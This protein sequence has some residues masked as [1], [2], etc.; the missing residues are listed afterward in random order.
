MLPKA[1]DYP[2][3]RK[4]VDYTHRLALTCMGEEYAYQYRKKQDREETMRRKKLSKI[5]ENERNT[6]ANQGK[7]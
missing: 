4:I 3:D 7:D 6:S 1:E 5:M 2:L